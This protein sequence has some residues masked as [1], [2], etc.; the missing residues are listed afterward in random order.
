MRGRGGCY[1]TLPGESGEVVQDFVHQQYGFV[2][3]SE[4]GEPVRS[5]S[6]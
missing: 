5:G 3:G 2:P 4:S 6:L 1:A